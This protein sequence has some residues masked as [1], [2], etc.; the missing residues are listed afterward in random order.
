MKQIAKFSMLLVAKIPDLNDKSNISKEIDPSK[1]GETQNNNTE[2]TNIKV[3]QT[4]NTLNNEDG[5]G[6]QKV[7]QSIMPFKNNVEDSKL[8]DI[9]I[10]LVTNFALN[11]GSPFMI[12]LIFK[13]YEKQLYWNAVG[14]F[15]I[16]KNSDYH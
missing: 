8:Y 7:N 15:A 10:P 2:Y 14:A 12:Y 4:I 13:S 1:E 9:Q 11:N 6:N 16:V 5:P 3:K